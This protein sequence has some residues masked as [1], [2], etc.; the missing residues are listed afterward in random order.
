MM[1]TYLKYS[2]KKEELDVLDELTNKL[3]LSNSK[4]DIDNDVQQLLN[5]LQ[6]LNLSKSKIA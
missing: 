2:G 1:Q 4:Q 5:S 6:D 3:S